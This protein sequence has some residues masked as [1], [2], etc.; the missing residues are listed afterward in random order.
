MKKKQFLALVMV[1]AAVIIGFIDGVIFGRLFTVLAFMTLGFFGWLFLY[2]TLMGKY[3]CF[4]L[5]SWMAKQNNK[6]FQV[7]TENIFYKRLMDWWEKIAL[8]EVK[9]AEKLEDIKQL[10]EIIPVWGDAYLLAQAK[11]DKLKQ[12]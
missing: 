6:R 7:G 3:P 2:K 1:F 11:I 5:I 9:K 12:T 10:I 4:W 8:D